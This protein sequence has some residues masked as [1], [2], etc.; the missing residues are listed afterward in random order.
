MITLDTSGFLALLNRKDRGHAA[1]VAI[2][3]ADGG[4]YY[5]PAGIL[6]EIG[7]FLEDRYRHLQADFLA[8]LAEGV[9][10]VDWEP[11]D[12]DRLSFLIQKYGNL[13]LS[14]ADSIVI[15]SAENHGG[16]VLTL[17]EHFS[18]VGRD[19]DVHITVSP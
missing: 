9:Y 19:P 2:L 16:E 6:S 15:L 7:W 4:P 18:I 1:C 3:E 10:T 5:L 8:D 14:I 17:D 12:F 11:L 13:P